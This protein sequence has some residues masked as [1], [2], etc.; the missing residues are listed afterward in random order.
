MNYS[1]D[2]M[3]S[4]ALEL[5]GRAERL[6]RQFFRPALGRPEPFWEPPVDVFETAREVLILT[7][8]PGVAPDD[9]TAV[10][11]AGVLV[12][13][14]TRTFPGEFRAAKI[15]RLELPQGRFERRVELPPGRY[16]LIR[17]AHANGCLVVSLRKAD[18]SA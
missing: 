14:G 3:W 16:D 7:A 11:E 17:R 8:L 5:L 2:W 1:R 15:H 10:I 12:I 4:D 9:V 18:G 6:Q 13:C